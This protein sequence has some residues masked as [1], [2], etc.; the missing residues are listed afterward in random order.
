LEIGVRN[1][2]DNFDW[3]E[4]EHKDSMDPGVEFTSNPVKYQMTSD[5]FFEFWKTNKLPKYDVIFI[6]GLHLADQVKRDIEHCL[7]MT[8]NEGVLILHDCNPPAPAFSRENYSEKNA[9]LGYWN[10]T[11]W[12]AFW[13]YIHEGRYDSRIIDSDWG[14]GIIDK[15]KK[16][17][18]TANANP[19]FEWSKLLELKKSSGRIL[20]FKEFKHWL[21]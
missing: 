2:E 18:P 8:S 21:N 1:P 19:L 9:A 10:G 13:A 5:A 3:I 4:C 17:E 11:T 12:K 6:D 14:I 16:K 15:S 7:E 20:S